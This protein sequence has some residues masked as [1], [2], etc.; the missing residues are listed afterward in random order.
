MPTADDDPPTFA[1]ARELPEA[2]QVDGEDLLLTPVLELEAAEPH[3]ERPSNQSSIPRSAPRN[4]QSAAPPPVE[5]IVEA[6]LFV[7]GPPLTAPHARAAVR[8]LNEERFQ[9]IV[10]GLNRKYRAQGRP[11]AIRLTGDGFT[12]A[13]KP[14]FRSVRDRLFGGPRE[15]RLSQPALDVLALIAYRQP[16][17]KG[18][19]DAVRGTDSG[20]V[21]R[22]LVRLGL[23]AVV[24]RGDAGRRDVAY[25]TTAR[26]LDLFGLNSPED[27]PRLGDTQAL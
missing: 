25:G 3:V 23:I 15:A 13:V 16:M 20:S 6:M 4:P 26:F 12:L 7:G 18:E 9:E 21:L 19:I 5:Q 2:W 24:Q 8:G 11:Y 17:S 27:L 10:D 1:A 14:A 22:Q